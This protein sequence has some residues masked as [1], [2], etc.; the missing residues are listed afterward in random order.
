MNGDTARRVMAEYAQTRESNQAEEEKRYAEVVARC[1]EIGKLSGERREAILAGARLAFTG[2]SPGDVEGKVAGINARIKA[3]LAKNGFAEDYLSPIYTCE[4]CRDTGYIG[5]G[6]RERC[7][8]FLEKAARLSFAEMQ[9]G[10]TFEQ[11][12]ETVFPEGERYGKD[13]LTQRELMRVMRAQC[14]RYADG[15]PQPKKN[16]LLLFG[17]SGLGKTFLLQCIYARARERGVSALCLTANVLLG[18]VKE[19]YFSREKDGLAQL[20]S[21]QL[22]LIDDL[23]TEPMLENIT[24][25]QLF[26]LLDARMTANRN[27][28]IST[29]L[30]LRKLQERYTERIASRLQDRRYYADLEFL[31]KDIRRLK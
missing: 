5:E 22:L 7:R 8:C 4:I 28:V 29:N 1:P 14:Q 10:A 13:N 23:G 24:I 9:G 27:T 30:S 2:R 19:A 21:V 26:F 25:E 12:D 3:L 20:Q 16:N 15:L 31:G 6:K 18:I 11:F 17:G